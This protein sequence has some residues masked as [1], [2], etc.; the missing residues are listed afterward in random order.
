MAPRE[1]AKRIIIL[2][3]LLMLCAFIAPVQAQT[4]NDTTS[5][6]RVQTN[7]GNEYIGQIIHQDD[8]FILLKTRTIGEITLARVNILRID[9]ITPEQIVNGQIWADNPQATR[10]F[11]A[12]NGYGL[13]RGEGYYQNIW[14]LFN[15]ASIGI[16]DNISIGVGTVPLFLFAGTASPVWL[17]PKISIPIVE[18]KFNLGA[19][20]LVGSVIGEAETGFALAYGVG[21][22][23]S[24][25]HNATFG[26]GYGY[27][28]GSWSTTPLITLSGMTRVGKN[29]YLLTENYIISVDDETLAIL[30]FGSRAIIRRVGLDFGLIFPQVSG[31]DGEFFALPWLGFSVPFNIGGRNR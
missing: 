17:T 8:E 12:P 20:A 3:F 4:E 6:Y 16:S 1:K 31:T 18:N 14:I 2:S 22:I 5:M 26:V 13:R 24:R 15:Q 21:T 25:N 10:Y 30:M 9:R 7:D 27:A 11:W 23:G 29:W 28:G 19:G